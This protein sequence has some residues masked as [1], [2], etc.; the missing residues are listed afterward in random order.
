MLPCTLLKLRPPLPTSRLSH[1][2][3]GL[4]LLGLCHLARVRGDAGKS[5]RVLVFGRA[6]PSQ[7][8]PKNGEPSG[9]DNGRFW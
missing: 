1:R 9:S 5:P 2:A 6:A 8:A 7:R 4:H 3:E